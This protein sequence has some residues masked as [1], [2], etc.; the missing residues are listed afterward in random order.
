MH[1]SNLISA[2]SLWLYIQV[3]KLLSERVIPLK[4]AEIMKCVVFNVSIP[5]Q[6]QFNQMNFLFA[7]SLLEK[8]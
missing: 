1:Q 6:Q 2:C 3:K 4:Q 8:E 7:L 5:F